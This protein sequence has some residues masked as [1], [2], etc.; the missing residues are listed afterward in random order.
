MKTTKSINING[1]DFPCEVEYEVVDCGIGAYD[2]WGYKGVDTHLC[3]EVTDI[4][5]HDSGVMK[6]TDIHFEDLSNKLAEEIEADGAIDD[7]WVSL[8]DYDTEL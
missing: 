7:Y 8:E 5:H 3:V 6:Y 1:N 2:F 4:I